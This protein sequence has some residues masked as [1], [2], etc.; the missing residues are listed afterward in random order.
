M[1]SFNMSS[2]TLTKQHF[3]VTTFTKQQTKAETHAFLDEIDPCGRVGPKTTYPLLA[4]NFYVLSQVPHILILSWTYHHDVNQ[5]TTPCYESS[6]YPPSQQLII[7]AHKRTS[8]HGAITR[9][10]GYVWWIK[11]TCGDNTSQSK[12]RRAISNICK[13]DKTR[14]ETFVYLEVI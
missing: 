13:S 14:T 5:P 9:H 3:L 1:D 2:T 7:L 10:V 6:I 11:Y 8:Q 4:F 12:E